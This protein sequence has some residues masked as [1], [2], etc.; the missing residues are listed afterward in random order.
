MNP[1]TSGPSLPVIEQIPG[2]L[3]KTNWMRRGIP[4]YACKGWASA[5][6]TV[7]PFA[8]CERRGQPR[9]GL[10]QLARFW[11]SVASYIGKNFTP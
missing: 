2:S 3:E 1:V 8:D 9:Q 10:G 7:R 5:K 6:D 4:K 11:F